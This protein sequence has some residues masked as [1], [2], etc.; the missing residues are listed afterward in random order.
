M[1]GTPATSLEIA[2][3]GWQGA[4]APLGDEGYLIR[5]TTIRGLPV[6]VIAANRDAGTLYGAFHFLRLLQTGQPLDRLDV[7]ERPRHA[8]R[9]LDHWDNLDGTIER[10]YAGRSLW[11][12][13]ELPRRVHPRILDYAR[14]NAS[15]GINGTVLN[16][17]NARPESLS[18]P[19]LEKTAALA[20]ALRPYGI[21]VYLSANFAAAGGKYCASASLPLAVRS[22]PSPA[23]SA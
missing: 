21:R 19:Y 2:A 17:V 13:E 9:I 16:N 15:L 12:W 14:A 6:T 10:G 18:R 23:A 11:N 22:K 4:L 1:V 8:R 3:L 7:A 5:S 20:G